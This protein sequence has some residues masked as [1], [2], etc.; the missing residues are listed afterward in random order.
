MSKFHT[1]S[2]PG[3]TTLAVTQP[4][5]ID[6]ILPTDNS[7]CTRTP[8]HI[9]PT[10]IDYCAHIPVGLACFPSVKKSGLRMSANQGHE[11]CEST[12]AALEHVHLLLKKENEQEKATCISVKV[13]LTQAQ[14]TIADLKEKLENVSKQ[15]SDKDLE[16]KLKD[17][18]LKENEHLTDELKDRCLKKSEECDR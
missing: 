6:Q 5:P 4:G 14:S 10:S 8:A 16:T 13:A 18:L 17:S 12:L 2:D 9:T 15:L 1:L 11:G 7:H 3:T